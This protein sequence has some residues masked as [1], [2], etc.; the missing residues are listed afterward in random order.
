MD[1]AANG[2]DYKTTR[3][4]YKLNFQISSE[5]FDLSLGVVCGSPFK[6]KFSLFFL[7]KCIHKIQCTFIES[8]VDDLNSFLASGETQNIIVFVQFGKV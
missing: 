1:V 3:H 4:P 7:L 5:L 8:Y 6:I 2:G